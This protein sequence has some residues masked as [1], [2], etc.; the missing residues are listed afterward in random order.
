M[1][2]QALGED[3]EVPFICVVRRS[4]QLGTGAI[5][6]PGAVRSTPRS[7]SSVG[8]RELQVYC[9]SGRASRMPY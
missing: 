7:P 1:E 6:P 9:I 8:P 2:P 5:A 4:C 3:M